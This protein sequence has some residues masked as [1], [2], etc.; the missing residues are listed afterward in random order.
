L[1][2]HGAMRHAYGHAA[3]GRRL[4]ALVPV[5]LIAEGAGVLAAASQEAAF[6]SS[7][8]AGLSAPTPQGTQRAAQGE[9]VW[10]GGQRCSSCWRRAA[11]TATLRPL[12]AAAAAA[13]CGT[14]ALS[15]A[16]SAGRRRRRRA[17]PRGAAAPAPPAPLGPARRP[18]TAAGEELSDLAAEAAVG[19]S[20]TDEDRRR[21][22]EVR[23]KR[24][25]LE[26]KIIEEDPIRNLIDKGEDPNFFGFPFVWVQIGHV[27]LGL[28]AIAAAL[29]GGQ[30]IEF[31]IFNLQG[32]ALEALRLAVEITVGMNV[33]VAGWIF[34][35]ELQ[36]GP[37][38]IFS[39]LGWG[40]KALL[41]GGVASWQRFG[42][43]SKAAKREASQ[44]P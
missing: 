34:Y 11:R 38:R 30:D 29:V 41:I 13:S 8:R 44:P 36:V 15:A 24:L 20:V 3:R 19:L 9:A 6:V 22:K 31:A 16:S 40:L 26:K 2:I 35:E 39:A 7:S 17:P 43:M 23:R 37:E 18:P 25:T 42:R 21:R 4:L 27:I 33:L 1:C 5:G 12:W 14:V 28:T 10:A 32:D